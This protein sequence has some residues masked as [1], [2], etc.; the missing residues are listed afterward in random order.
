MICSTVI[1]YA[2]E[3]VALIVLARLL[4][5]VPLPHE[6]PSVILAVLLGT[7]A[8]AAIGHRPDRADPLGRRRLRGRERHLPAD[9]VPRGRVLVGAVVPAFPAK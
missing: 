5:D 2:I 8:F 3:A 1:V 7:L 6:W 9:L 4:Y